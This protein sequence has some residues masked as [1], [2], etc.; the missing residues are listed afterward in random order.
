MN[1]FFKLSQLRKNQILKRI[2]EAQKISLA[3]LSEEFKVSE[4]TIRRDLKP[5]EESR[6]IKI[7][8][9]EIIWIPTD[10]LS[11]S[12]ELAPAEETIAEMAAS[13]VDEQ[14]RIIWIGSGNISLGIARRIQNV[15]L[16]TN[17]LLTA[18]AA[19]KRNGVR[20][21]LVGEEVNPETYCLYGKSMEMIKEYTFNKAFVEVDG[22][23]NKR[24]LTS[25]E[26]AETSS[27]LTG[28][29][30]EK[31]IVIQGSNLGNVNTT[32]LKGLKEFKSVYTDTLTKS[33]LREI[34]QIPLNV[35]SRNIEVE[36][37]NEKIIPLKTKTG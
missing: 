4:L 6:R 12:S 3:E 31:I 11:G 16:V 14:D 32:R 24:F 25:S 35:E 23:F 26:V 30:L 22:Y 1:I 8:K 36:K 27:L 21:F 33:T 29:V 15:I 7:G 28:N 18:S 19:I 2:E 10:P 37:H 5:L 9:G 17:S 20:V 13:Q 34:E